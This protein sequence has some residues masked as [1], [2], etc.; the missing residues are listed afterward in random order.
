MKTQTKPNYQSQ[1]RKMYKVTY[2]H[3]DDTSYS[4]TLSKS[5]IYESIKNI[6]LLYKAIKVEE[7]EKLKG[8]FGATKGIVKKWEDEKSTWFECEKGHKTDFLI[9]D[10]NLKY[11]VCPVCNP[12][13]KQHIVA[14]IGIKKL[15]LIQKI[16]KYFK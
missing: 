16:K 4:Q 9:L 3:S 6:G 8:V 5:Q 1:E 15:S 13:K 14:E 12:M 10:K 2:Y 7:I 11:E